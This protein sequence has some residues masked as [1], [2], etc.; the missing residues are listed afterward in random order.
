MSSRRHCLRESLFLSVTYRR[1]EV[2]WERRPRRGPNSSWSPRAS[3][4]S[5]LTKYL[6]SQKK[7]ER[8][9]FLELPLCTRHTTATHTLCTLANNS[10]RLTVSFFQ[11][12]TRTLR[13]R[14]ESADLCKG[15]RV[16]IGL[17]AR[18]L[19]PQAGGYERKVRPG[20][21]LPSHPDSSSWVRVQGLS[22]I[23]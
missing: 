3:R 13:V 7:R 14:L 19:S 16:P 10:A 20:P 8:K 11:A 21:C 1:V 5:N 22:R 12:T 23:L 4:L 15:S 17:T 18:A 9:P 6:W 2:A